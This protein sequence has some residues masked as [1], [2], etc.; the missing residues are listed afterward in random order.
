MRNRALNLSRFGLFPKSMSFCIDCMLFISTLPCLSHIGLS[1]PNHTVFGHDI[2]K[3][4]KQVTYFAICLLSIS[5]YDV[6]TLTSGSGLNYFPYG[7]FLLNRN[8]MVI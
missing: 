7:S 5:Q 6:P 3:V 1:I 2:S 8:T 4:F